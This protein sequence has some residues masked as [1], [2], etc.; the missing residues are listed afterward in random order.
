MNQSNPA[1]ARDA[2][3]VAVVPDTLF[4]TP[5]VSLGIALAFNMAWVMSSFQSMGQFAA[6]ADGEQML[7]T[8][9]FVSSLAITVTLVAAGLMPEKARRLMERRLSYALLPLGMSVSNLCTLLLGAPGASSLAVLTAAGVLSG[10]TSGLFLLRFGITL[11]ILDTRRA[12]AAAA[13]AYIAAMVLF[14]MGQLFETYTYVLFCASLPIASAF[15]LAFGTQTMHLGINALP[16]PPQRDPSDLTQTR[17]LRKLIIAFALAPLIA[18]AVNYTIRTI[19]IQANVVAANGGMQSYMTAVGAGGLLMAAGAIAICLLMVSQR[20]KGLLGARY[21]YSLVIGLLVLD[22]ALA[23]SVLI[24]PDGPTY[25][26]TSFNLGAF[27][28]FGMFVWV[29]ICG[30]CHHYYESCIRAF[31]FTRAGWAA[32]TLVG[33]VAG[34]MLY[35]SGS[36]SLQTVYPFCIAGIV[37]LLCVPTFVFTN[38]HLTMALNI[39]PIAPRHRFREKCQRVIDQYGLSAREGE[40]M[41]LFAKGHTLANIQE[42]LHLSKS[43][44]STHRQH[45]YQKMGI[46]SIQELI[47]IVDSM[48]EE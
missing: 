16:L 12:T 36:F 21:C 44:V 34:Q 10:I 46:H 2:R 43:T 33:Q 6:F 8:V 26:A 3:Q 35:F 20:A 39:L 17:R 42:E 24:Y 38:E 23:P 27:Q 29:L 41:T 45:I 7:N 48:H 4:S 14:L 31:A 32:G 11:S 9:Y 18:C 1:N 28:C 13:I 22:A 40:V 15:M 47:A 25:L 5:V 19:H 30:L 37:A